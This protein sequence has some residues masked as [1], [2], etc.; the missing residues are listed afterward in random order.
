MTNIFETAWNWL[1]EVWN[2]MASTN[3]ISKAFNG[4][5]L[6]VSDE[7]RQAIYRWSEE[8]QGRAGWLTDESL[9]TTLRKGPLK[10][11]N[12]PSSISNELARLVT[13]EMAVTLSGGARATYLQTQLNY[14]VSAL[15]VEVEYANSLG[16]MILKPYVEGR[17]ICV[18]YIQADRMFPIRFDSR[19]DIAACVFVDQ[20]VVGK[21]Y[22]TKLEK[23][24]MQTD[25]CH[26]DNVLFRST[27]KT[28]IGVKCELT[29]VAEWADLQPSAVILNVDRPLF[30]YYKWPAANLVDKSKM[31]V[32]CYAR[33]EDLM[34]EA[35]E[36]WTDFLWEY[37]SG[38]R[39]LY[40]DEDAF[41]KNEKTK[42]PELPHKLLYR[43]LKGTGSVEKETLFKDWS[44]TIRANELA[45]G[46]NEVLDKIEFGTGLATGT[47]SDPNEVAKT[48]TE[49]VTRRQ[50]TQS[51][52]TD[53]QKS[54]RVAVDHLLYAMDTYAT[55]YSLA[56]AGKVEATYDF[57]DSVVVD[58]AA[59][60]DLDLRL[61][62]QTMMSRVKWRMRN[63][64]EP[65][66]VAKAEVLEAMRE[67]SELSKLLFEPS[68]QGA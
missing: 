29:E 7:M 27:S 17:N 20:R 21:V 1:R 24:D 5:Q 37:E 55:I 47:F 34:K 51:T 65:E 42:K 61:V 16:G 3:D 39:A 11:L 14:V 33:V 64:K 43:L 62:S 8:Y 10:S 13:I 63:F 68:D 40:A 49:V 45:V 6:A 57:D 25:G 4:V 66:D 15:R 59:Q 28:E 44:P 23:H 36:L 19:G 31:G 46:L 32:S 38:R 30:S 9:S 41:K 22:Y 18:E 56:P 53:A 48:A 67:S 60:S 50:R 52:I 58:K 12:L 26:V 35:D 2:R 54:L